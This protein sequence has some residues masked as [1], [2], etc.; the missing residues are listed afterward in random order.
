[1]REE[2]T[3]QIVKLEK[4]SAIFSEEDVDEDGVYH[5]P[6][7]FSSV[8]KYAFIGF[9]NPKIKKIVFG[10]K[11]QTFDGEIFQ[12]LPSNCGEVDLS[13]T[14]VE[15]LEVENIGIKNSKL[16]YVIFPKTLTRIGE[17]VFKN[18]SELESVEFHKDTQLKI[19]GESAFADCEALRKIEIPDN[20][21][22]TEIG[23]QA[24]V[25]CK[26]LEEVV[27]PKNTT[28]SS[29]AFSLC[30][31]L[32]RINI[33]EYSGTAIGFNAFRECS[34]LEKVE[35]PE[36]YTTIDN[37]LFNGCTSLKEVSLPDSI[38]GI[39]FSVFSNDRNLKHIRFPQGLKQIARGAFSG[40]DLETLELPDGLK[41]IEER[42]FSGNPH[43]KEVVIPNSV[44]NVGKECFADCSS[45]ERI[46]FPDVF[47]IIREF[48]RGLCS[49]REVILPKDL[50]VIDSFAF[51]NSQ[52]EH[53]DIP[54]TLKFIYSRA[55]KC[56]QL[57]EFIMPEGDLTQMYTGAFRECSNLERVVLPEGLRFI[58]SF[59]FAE[60]LN[61]KE[62]TLPNSLRIIE[63]S[64]FSHCESLEH[65]KIGNGGTT[66]EGELFYGCK[67]LKTITIEK[68]KFTS[69][70]FQGVSSN[71][72]YIKMG[73]DCKFDDYNKTDM[74]YLTAQDGYFYLSKGPINND[75]LDISKIC[76]EKGVTVS[77]AMALWNER[78]FLQKI[79]DEDDMVP[80]LLIMI[81][82]QLGKDGLKQFFS[83]NKNNLKFFKQIKINAS[84]ED[85]RAFCKLY[86]NLGGFE[87]RYKYVKKDKNGNETIVEINYAQK[88]GEFL[89]EMTKLHPKFFE[90]SKENFSKMQLDGIKKDFTDFMLNKKNFEDIIE[91]NKV[92]N[93]FL[94]TFYNEFEFAQKLNTSNKGSQR[95]LKPTLK[96][97]KL[98]VLGNSFDGVTEEN[99]ATAMTLRQYFIDQHVFEK[100]LKIEAEKKEKNVGDHILKVPMFEK[101]DE[102]RDK[103]ALLAEET[104]ST[105]GEA[106]LNKY[107]FEMLSK[108]DPTNF[109]LGKLC[110]CCAH[111]DGAGYSIMRASIIC[112]DV[113]NLVIRDENGTIV[114]KTTLYINTKEGYGVCNTFEVSGKIKSDQMPIIKYKFLKALEQFATQY[115]KDYPERKR[116]T[117][118]N[119]GD[120]NNDLL[121][122][123]DASKI[124]RENLLQSIQYSEYGDGW[125][126]YNGD[127][128]DGQIV[129]WQDEKK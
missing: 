59:A 78:K 26:N 102:T 8:D 35:I 34:S 17:S 47:K 103:I 6:D 21:Q 64:A 46:V 65:I 129:V 126:D 68:A 109:V 97:A 24:F 11:I 86:Y 74:K 71:L 110:D 73:S 88:V 128:A 125:G 16:K 90:D 121:H 85:K 19:I 92:F 118:I 104:L 99:M 13:Q 113:Q 55:F 70:T 14:Q 31:R 66:L 18:F 2:Q 7:H 27:L 49:L 52:V 95:Q 101:I 33:P 77:C 69:L 96:V 82:E 41:S 123:F 62:I 93:L 108:S 58:E 30:G 98:Y 61:L 83:E 38:E 22:K 53:L 112:P 10:S 81:N 72:Q 100:A 94:T 89:K 5:V 40:C 120:N 114:A 20:L 107:T 80:D 127:S 116:L 76:S 1:M 32:K 79:V 3:G 50:E 105:L 84:S 60:C 115:N 28:L 37:N 122:Y 56:S 119:V 117:Q 43:L 51:A 44:E 12:K 75:S 36:G 111:L 91:E 42:A 39:G 29:F 15:D 4:I 54:R 48:G 45:L 23:V 9:D 124:E 67:N 57:R 106:A 87:P 63:R 25:S